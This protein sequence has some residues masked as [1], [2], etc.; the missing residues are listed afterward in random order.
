M[1]VGSIYVPSVGPESARI[2]CVGEA[3]GRDEELEGE[4]F[5]G[6]SGQLLNRYFERH[7]VLRQE[8]F[9]TNLLKYRPKGNKFEQ[10]LGTSEL[11]SGLIELA[12]EVDR[13]NP[14]IIIAL[15]GWPMYYLTGMK[16]GSPGSGITSWRASFLESKPEFGSR[17][18]MPTYHPAYILRA[19][20]WNPV[21]NHDLG[22]AVRDSAF[23]EL[24]LPNYTSYID[25]D[26]DLLHELLKEALSARWISTDIETFPN[27][28]FSCIGFCW[29]EQKGVCITFQRPDL[30][31]Y[32]QE[33]WESPTPKI[34]QYGTYDISF[35]RF[36][37]NWKIGGYYN[38]V[39]WDTYVASANLLPDF[40]RRLDFLCSLYTRF[41]YYKEERK[42]WKEGGD[43]SVLWEY[44]IKDV[45]ATYQIAM[46]QMKDMHDLY[47]SS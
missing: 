42:V 14:N 44:N 20:S 19:W 28:T 40:P 4:P 41:P 24:R 29:D 31:W 38:N 46:A 21:F 34:L 43:M 17:K 32:L 25:P 37:Y 2:M 30:W 3:P 18:V 39:G 9:L 5:V 1:S 35:M 6:V 27:G 11:E 26:P 15:G 8:V 36:F 7:G 22:K 10:A 23:P 33:M 12:E 13:V 16:K 45:I 47:P